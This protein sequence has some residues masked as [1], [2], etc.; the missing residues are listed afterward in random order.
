DAH[1]LQAEAEVLLVGRDDHPAAGDLVADESGRQALAAGDEG[2]LGGGWGPGG[3]LRLGGGLGGPPGGGAGGVGPAPPGHAPW[4]GRGLPR[5]S[6]WRGGI[7]ADIDRPAEGWLTIVRS[8]LQTGRGR[9]WAFP[10]HPARPLRSSPPSRSTRSG[11]PTHG[12]EPL[13]RPDD[14]PC[15]P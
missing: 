11:A 10:L 14:P 6:K 5:V 4:W 15:L 1:R 13:D 2:H 7:S 8:S 9:A 12:V 3:P